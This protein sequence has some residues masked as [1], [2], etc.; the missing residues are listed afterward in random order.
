MVDR[1][2]AESLATIDRAIDLGITFFDTA[3]IYGSTRMR[4]WSDAEF[5]AKRIAL[6][7]R[8]SLESCVT[9]IRRDFAELTA[10]QEYVN[11]G[12]P[13]RVCAG[14]GIDAFMLL[15]TSGR[16]ETPIEETVGAMAEAGSARRRCA[17]L[18][19]SKLVL[20]PSEGRMRS[21]LLPPCNRNTHSDT[22]S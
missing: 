20:T 8:Q 10:N 1:D 18:G 13:K 3:D 21:I 5:A 7:S 15:P 14:L 6:L 4:N 11:Q 17:Y 12:V 22:R 2:D 16:S 9:R 19:L